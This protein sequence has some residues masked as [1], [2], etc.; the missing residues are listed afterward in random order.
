MLT[1]WPLSRPQPSFCLACDG[2]LVVSQL[3]ATH[4]IDPTE[5]H[6]N[7]LVAARS[8]MQSCG[9]QVELV[10]VHGHQDNGQL[11]VLTRDAWLNVEA[12]SLVKQKV[13]QPNIGPKYY[14]LPSNL[15]SCYIGTDQIVKQFTITLH[16]FIHGKEAFDYWTKC[17]Q[18]NKEQ[19]QEIDWIAL[20]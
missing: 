1:F 13:T 12:D 18:M 14:K 3:T 2:L 16:S 5:P 8:L 15:W 9:Y 17:K 6:A 20:G 7:L 10:F 19:L 11:T 4:P